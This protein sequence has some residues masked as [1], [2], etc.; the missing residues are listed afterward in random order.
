MFVKA[1]LVL[2]AAILLAS[3]PALATDEASSNDGVTIE[4]FLGDQHIPARQVGRHH[5]HDL[6]Y[7]R[8]ECF[9]RGR[10][11]ERRVL[12]LI[13]GR[14]LAPLAASYVRIYEHAN[15]SGSSMYLSRDYSHLGAIGWND[16]ISSYYVINRGSGE[17]YEHA[18]YIGM[19][20]TFCCNQQIANVG[21]IY[22][23]K[24]SSVA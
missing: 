2:G 17:F 20:D 21:A 18:M 7:P 19:Y 23:D 14:V 10:A 24:F 22:N 9:R 8:I 11:L 3:A 15:Y 13:E 4:A 16:R 12:S 5:C 6:G 1:A